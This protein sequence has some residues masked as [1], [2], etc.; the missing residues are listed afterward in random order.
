MREGIDLQWKHGKMRMPGADTGHAFLAPT[1]AEAVLVQVPKQHFLRCCGRWDYSFL[2]RWMS[3]RLREHS[4][5]NL[6]VEGFPKRKIPGLSF[7]SFPL[8]AV[9]EMCYLISEMWKREMALCH[10]LCLSFFLSVSLFGNQS[11]HRMHAFS[12]LCFPVVRGLAIKETGIEQL[13]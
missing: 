8:L 3:P 6:Y 12:F 2:W 4:F 5:P 7:P 11:S 9:K 10:L 1:G 13:Y